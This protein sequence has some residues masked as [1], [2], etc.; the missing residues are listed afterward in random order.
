MMY[1]VERD[2]RRIIRTCSTHHYLS[3]GEIKTWLKEKYVLDLV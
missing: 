1:V 2:V 3:M